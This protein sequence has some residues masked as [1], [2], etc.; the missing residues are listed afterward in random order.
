MFFCR[1][2]D[3]FGSSILLLI[4]G[5]HSFYGDSPTISLTRILFSIS[6]TASAILDSSS[7]TGETNTKEELV[8]EEKEEEE[9]EDTIDEK[10]PPKLFL[11]LLLLQLERKWRTMI[12]Q[13]LLPAAT[14]GKK[15]LV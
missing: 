11:L 12:L 14:K 4:C 5:V 10:Q 2:V 1:F 9:A 7:N 6:P 3:S 8:A 15:K 13:Q